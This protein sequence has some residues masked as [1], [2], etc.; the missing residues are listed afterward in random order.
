[1]DDL[2]NKLISYSRSDMYP[3]HM[4]GHK[5]RHV[6]AETQ[7][8]PFALDVTEVEGFGNLH[9]PLTQMHDVPGFLLVNGATGGILAAVRTLTKFGDRVIMARN[10]HKS[11]YN[12]VELCGLTAEFIVPQP[13]ADRGQLLNFY[14][15][16]TPQQIEDM[17]TAYPDTA[18]VIITSPTYEGMIS[19]IRSIAAICH[20]HGARLFVDEAH[21][22]HPTLCKVASEADIPLRFSPSATALGA[23][24]SVFSLHK[25]L[26]ALTQTALLMTGDTL[27]N[28]QQVMSALRSNLAVFQTSSPSYVLMASAQ[29]ALKCMQSKQ[30]SVAYCERLMRFLQDVSSL[31]HLKILFSEELWN[32]EHECGKLLISTRGTDMTGYALA[33]QL[34]EIYHLE[35]EMATPDYVLALST[36]CDTDEGFNRLAAALKTIDAACQRTQAPQRSYLL[37]HVPPRVFIPFEKYKYSVRRVALSAAEG[38][39]SMETVMAY[40]P[41]IPCIVPGEV[42]TRE[43][44]DYIEYIKTVGGEI[45]YSSMADGPYGCI[46]V[47]D[48]D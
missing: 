29:Q 21:G 30:L 36:V 18:L 17:L 43:I 6:C 46:N 45:I 26:P 33:K 23:D 4:P 3:F 10:C 24:T 48:G 2:Y 11:V 8:L 40:P 38:C 34:R 25:T 47:A 16:V 27:V 13:A 12:A 35:T 19:D 37:H 44:I 22:A 42:F 1:M 31:S 15:S 7:A 39:I 41:G 32:T 14:G 5:R 9:H 20:R 28:N